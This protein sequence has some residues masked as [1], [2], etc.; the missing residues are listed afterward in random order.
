MDETK[1]PGSS[2]RL[3]TKPF[4][5]DVIS[6]LLSVIFSSSRRACACV[7]LGARELELGLRRLLA[8]FGVVQRLA[9]EQLALEQAARPIEVGLR[10]TSGR[11]RAAERSRVATSNDASAWLHLFRISRS[12]TRASARP[13]T[14]RSPRRTETSS[15]RPFTLLH[16]FD[17]RLANQLP[18]TVMSSAMTA[19]DGRAELHGHGWA[20]RSAAACPP[21]TA[22]A[23]PEPAAG[24]T[25]VA[26][27]PA[28]EDRR[29]GRRGD[30]LH[31]DLRKRAFS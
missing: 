7:E 1:A 27:R 28:T 19:R 12:S 22:P 18:T 17:R 13:L 9:G 5:G 8:G 14:T 20:A 29:R 2:M 26:R 6:V 24:R 11:P 15:S 31:D 16:D 30:L 21:P 23:S 10:R 25:P 3:P 4:T